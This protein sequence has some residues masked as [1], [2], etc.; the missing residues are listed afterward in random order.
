MVRLLFT[1]LDLGFSHSTESEDPKVGDL[2]ESFWHPKGPPESPQDPPRRPQE[3]PRGPPEDKQRTHRER[4]ENT[5]R[6]KPIYTID[7]ELNSR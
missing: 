5:Q 3:T 6:T 7:R 2:W 4:T 1:F